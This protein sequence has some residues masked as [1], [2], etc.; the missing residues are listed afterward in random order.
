MRAVWSGH[1]LPAYRTNGYFR[2]CRWTEKSLVRSCICAGWS[3]RYLPKNGVWALC[4]RW[5]SNNKHTVAE[6][7]A[8][9]Y[10][11]PYNN[12]IPA[13][14]A[15]NFHY[16]EQNGSRLS[17]LIYI[18]YRLILLYLG[19]KFYDAIISTRKQ[20]FWLFFLYVNSFVSNVICAAVNCWAHLVCLCTCTCVSVCFF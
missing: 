11:T 9:V 19:L 17:D 18:I 1:S 4:L 5:E 7:F 16:I 13:I 12:R 20:L 8:K 14:E 3:G 15:A 2:T 6:I 10:I